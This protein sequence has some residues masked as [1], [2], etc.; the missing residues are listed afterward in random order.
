MDE[1]TLKRNTMEHKRYPDSTETKVSKK[2]ISLIAKDK[3][4]GEITLKNGNSAEAL[5][6]LFYEAKTEVVM[7]VIGWDDMAFRDEPLKQLNK[8]LERHK[9]KL[10]IITDKK[11]TGDIPEFLSDYLAIGKN[12]VEII[13]VSADLA[14]KLLDIN[15][16]DREAFGQF[17]VIAD[18][19]MCQVRCYPC[20]NNPEEM[21]SSTSFSRDDTRMATSYHNRLQA[22]I[23]HAK[24]VSSASREK[25]IQ[26][27]SA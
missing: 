15:S 17:P 23:D 4:K 25:A 27:E 22:L 7:L 21:Y 14:K 19:I 9:T 3:S 18:E 20:K 26:L 6:A 16:L 8:F 11:L 10:T 5:A 12:K 1:T 2:G 24:G 13:V